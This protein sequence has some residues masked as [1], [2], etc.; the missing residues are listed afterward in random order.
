MENLQYDSDYEVRLA[1]LKALG[2]DDTKHY[3]SVYDIDIEILKLT[4]QGGGGATI[5]DDVISTETAWSSSK[6]VSELADAGFTV[7]IVDELPEVG[8]PKKIYLVPADETKTQNI[9]DEFLYI[10]NMWE[11]I[12]STAIDL[13]NYYT[14][15]EV[16]DELDLKEDVITD[17]DEI[18]EGAEAGATA[19]QP[20]QLEE[21]E[22]VLS[23]G[24]KQL[25][26]S[27]E[28]KQ[29][30][31]SDLATIRSGAALGATA[32]QSIPVT[33][34]QVVILTQ[35]EYD[36]LETKDSHTF[37]VISDAQ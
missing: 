37:Y 16:D 29:D 24:M 13:S 26:D 20:A 27:I 4:E 22:S 21:V 36:A 34:S 6:I 28:D 33:Y 18:R 15:D 32:L 9:Y 31:I 23:E 14:K 17:L 12:G 2:G 35:A 11:Q 3:N 1:T 30:T 7:E 5:D 8:D 19:I 25:K 10:N